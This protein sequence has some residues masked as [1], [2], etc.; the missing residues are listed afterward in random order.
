VATGT[1]APLI[2]GW[3]TRDPVTNMRPGFAHILDNMVIE[4]GAPRVRF[5]WRPWAT[6]LPGRVDGILP[7]NG[8]GVSPRLFASSGT[9]IYE[10]TTA[11]AVGAA[12]VTGLS[13]ARWNSI[14][15][16]A[17][18]ASFLFAFNGTDTP[19]TFDGTTWATWTGT[20]VTGGVAWATTLAGRLFVGNTNRLSFF[21]GAA[22]AIGGAFTEFPL[23]GVAQ[24]GGGIIAAGVL[25]GDGGLGPQALTVFLTTNGEALVYSGTDPSNATT[26]G[27]VGRWIMPRVVGGPHRCVAPYGGDLLALTELGVL[28]LSSLRSGTN[29]DEALRT[30]GLTRTIHPTWISLVSE[31]GP[32]AFGWQILPLTKYGYVVMNV[33]WGPATAQQVVLSEGGALSRW[34]GIAAAVWGVGLGGRVF[35]GDAATGRVMLYGEDNSDNG[36]GIRSEALSAFSVMGAPS[37]VKRV[38]LVQPILRDASSFASEVRVLADWQIP[39]SQVNALG[40]SAVA[41]A[42]P[43]LSFAGASLIW[44]VGNW[45]VNLWAGDQDAVTRDWRSGGSVGHSHAVLIRMV[46]G[47]GRPQLIGMNITF[48]VGGVTR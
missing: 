1:I 38:Q 14:N 45:D 5:G 16:G 7:W 46:S 28:P 41:P 36:F 22:G 40:A 39:F 10:T 18:G 31:R 2:G 33:P 6:G 30:L 47:V 24:N 20:G 32:S 12:V 37:R 21:Y 35:V 8:T 29:A 34:A 48:E 4:G 11:G 19:R 9:G 17:A 15:V 27:L 42:L 25:S 26:W 3:N 23:Q 13:H 43:P 44:D